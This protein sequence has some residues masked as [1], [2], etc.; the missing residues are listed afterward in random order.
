M[1]REKIKRF[2]EDI[3]FIVGLSI[4]ITGFTYFVSWLCREYI[5]PHI[6]EAFVDAVNRFFGG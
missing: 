2:L 3:S 4:C 6:W 5:P 1:K